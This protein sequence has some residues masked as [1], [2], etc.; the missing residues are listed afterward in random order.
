MGEL[1]QCQEGRALFYSVSTQKQPQIS[2]E[3]G[4]ETVPFKRLPERKLEGA[5]LSPIMATSKLLHSEIDGSATHLNK[6]V[7]GFE[8]E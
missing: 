5:V 6:L 4:D 2:G 3:L 7:S 1:V 8:C